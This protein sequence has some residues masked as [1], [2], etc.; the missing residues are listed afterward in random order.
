MSTIA[1]PPSP[2]I[3]I[4][5]LAKKYADARAT[6]AAK[7]TAF[8]DE[9]RELRKKHLPAIKQAAGVAAQ[10]QS[11]LNAE[12]STHPE[13]FTKP[14]AMVLHG[15]KLGYQK[16]KG[17]V[18]WDDQAKVV[19]RIYDLVPQVD[20]DALLDVKTTV[21]KTALLT[22]DAST[23]KKLGCRIVDT[24]DTIIIKAADGEVDKLVAKILEEGAVAEGGAS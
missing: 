7:V 1:T 10:R 22:L 16:G 12:I 4:D 6:L 11:E 21:R 5:V 19:R 3:A 9:I 17:L 24:G 2:I 15:I 14:R 18:E 8:E 20:A 13:L 23:L